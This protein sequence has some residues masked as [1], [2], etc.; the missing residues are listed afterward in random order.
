MQEK[1]RQKLRK[2][3]ED[4]E[5]YLEDVKNIVVIFDRKVGNT[6]CGNVITINNCQHL[7]YQLHTL[8]HEAGHALIRGNK[9]RF[10]QKFPGLQKRRNSKSFKLDTLKEEF[11]AWDKGFKLAKRLDI[12]LDE[13]QWKR[14][15]EQCLHEYVKWVTGE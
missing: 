6:Y 8:L 2:H 14:H 7:R 15:S 10:E 5:I 12:I 1:E 11:E 9:K 4:V 13:K 3:I